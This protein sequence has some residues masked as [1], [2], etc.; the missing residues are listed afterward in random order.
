MW[1]CQTNQESLR[2]GPR[3]QF[4]G[5]TKPAPLSQGGVASGLEYFAGGEVALLVEVVV[6]GAVYR[7]EF[8]Q[9]S[10]LPEAKHGPFPSSEGEVAV[11]GPVIEPPLDN[12]LI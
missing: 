11:L 6:D 10:H 12:A 2:F 3:C 1:C 9:T 7:D 8:L 5:R 4:S